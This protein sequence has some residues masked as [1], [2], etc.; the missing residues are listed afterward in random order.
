MSTWSPRSRPRPPASPASWRRRRPKDEAGGALS[1][2]LA[3]QLAELDGEGA[4]LRERWAGV[5]G[6]EPDPEQAM[7]RIRA[8]RELIT[9]PPP[10][11]SRI[12]TAAPGSPRSSSARPPL[13]GAGGP[14]GPR[15][16]SELDGTTAGLDAT[17]AAATEELETATLAAETAREPRP[18][19]LPARHR[20][21][22]RAEALEAPW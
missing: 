3:A 5:L 18:T 15:P 4:A 16:P 6:G 19:R 1:A 17:L 7:A 11:S 8:R 2:E 12:S 9:T 13:C 21:E 10:A 20:S 22:A 14:A